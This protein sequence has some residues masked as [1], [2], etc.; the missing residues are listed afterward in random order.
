MSESYE[1][2]TTIE[3]KDFQDKS[4]L[5]IGA[6]NMARQYALAL[7]KMNFKDVEVISNSESKVN[8]LC[9]EFGYKPHSGGFEKML[10][11]I[12]EKDLVIIATPID[13]L[14]SAARLALKCGHTT[15][16][17]EK[18][19]SLYSDELMSL[20]KTSNRARIRIGYQRL[21]YP[22]FHKLIQLIKKDGGITSCRFTF[23]EL[24]DRINF[25]A[26]PPNVFQYWGISNSL[27][28]ISMAIHLIGFPK[29]MSS[30]KSGF[31][32]WHKSGTVFVGSGI[33][34]NE[35][36]F[37]YHADWNSAGRWGVEVMT[38][39]NSYRLLPL[40]ELQI[41]KLGE[42]DWQKVPI[43]IS[44]SDIKPGIAEEIAVMLDNDFNNI[45]LVTL[46]EAA[47]LNSL[48]EKIFGYHIA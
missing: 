34:E 9:N 44:F 23:T 20:D 18:P 16:L 28:V 47:R 30:Y 36:P 48:A 13:S 17:I 19:G 33:S 46:S 39:K 22:S 5:M 37:S 42:M 21:V 27:H 32:S 31:F 15:I 8:Q 11:S 1:L 6:G 35:I 4:V 25:N 29:K 7:S 38:A 14:V 45:N 41:C 3:S 43:K 40:E 2:L 12:E 26:H 10:P 24:I